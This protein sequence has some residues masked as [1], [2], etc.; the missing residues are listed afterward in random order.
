MNK[1]K[2]CVAAMAVVCGMT[3][4]AAVPQYA[5]PQRVEASEAMFHPIL[6][7]D[8]SKLLY[9]AVDHTGLKCFDMATGEVEVID[10]EAAAG[11]SP[12]FSAD[13]SKVYYRTAIVENRLLKRDVR[14]F[15]MG[16]RK[17]AKLQGYSRNQVEVKSLAKET[18]AAANFSHI[19][20][21]LKGK[22]AKLSPVADA[23]S[24]LWP[25]LS[26]DGT[27]MLFT[28]PFQGVFV[29]NLDG[30]NAKAYLPKGDYPCWIDDN[31]VAA[32]VSHDDGYVITDSKVVVVD[33][34]TGETVDITTPDVLVGELTVSL[35]TGAIVYTTLE[36][37]VYI[38]NPVK[39]QL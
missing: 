23:Y 31:T 34:A 18:F 24:Y 26:P 3:A 12:E 11:F 19:N 36:G 10:S 2:T 7:P 1:F 29:C 39:A 27:R 21:S 20:L 9:T 32:V 6:S 15:D 35:A 4:F 37:D 38:V 17:V 22:V 13:G 28:E 14:C 5:A 8:G 25:S 33:L 16:S 30:S